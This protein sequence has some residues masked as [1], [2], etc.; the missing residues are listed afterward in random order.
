M[1]LDEQAAKNGLARKPGE[2]DGGLWMRC[3]DRCEET[4]LA[5]M[6]REDANRFRAA[7]AKRRAYPDEAVR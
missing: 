7:V 6:S 3:L 5:A 2:S 4:M 1:T